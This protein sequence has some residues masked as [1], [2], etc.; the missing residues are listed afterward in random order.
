MLERFVWVGA[1]AVA[2][3]CTQGSSSPSGAAPAASASREKPRESLGRVMVDVGRRFEVAGRA[4]VANRF[5]LAAFEAGELTEAFE[6]DV[7]GA[8]LPK[9]G[10]TAHIPAMAKTFAK[11][12]AP[13]LARAAEA[14][15]RAAFTAAFQRASAACNA[16]HQAS[17]KGYIHV[18]SEPGKGVPDLDPMPPPASSR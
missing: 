17:A 15:D 4:V 6:D 13:E 2:L 12:T 18:P 16:C 11:A 3:G 7:P 8:E 1:I 9:E 5:E 14:R 10:P